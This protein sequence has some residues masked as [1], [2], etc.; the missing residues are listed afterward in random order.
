MPPLRESTDKL[1]SPKQVAKAI[2]AS[3]SSLKRWCD[4]G[5]IKTVKTAGGHRR[6]PVHEA[7]R[8]VR[9][10]NHAVVEPHI[11]SMTA[12][13]DRKAR[14]IEGVAE[15]LTEALLSNNE[16]TCRAI[17]FDMFLAGESV[18]RIFDDV[19][20]AAFRAIGD[21]WEF[22]EAEVYQE[23]CSCQI[24]LRLLHEL[25]SHQVPPNP[26]CVALGATIEGDQY[27]LPGTM[28]EIVL[29]S[30]DWDARLLGTSIPFDSMVKAVETHSPELFWLS[31]SFIEDEA[32][33]IAGFHRLSAAA[34]KTKTAIV[35]G[36]RAL[37]S[38]IRTRLS[39]SA[40]CDTMRHLEEF[41]KTMRRQTDIASQKSRKTRKNA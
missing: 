17:V 10:Q 29:R 36:G 2:G 27:V 28:A 21:K 24:M 38:E 34:S 26:S 6:I 35:V 33:F 8:F 40:F 23:R 39:Y 13:T 4:Q 15:R 18:S 3:E 31:V 12:T 9:E 14:R 20:A 32:A 37:T 7:L 19:V 41:G 22:H 5:L 1:L 11:L 16:L 30:V 25:R